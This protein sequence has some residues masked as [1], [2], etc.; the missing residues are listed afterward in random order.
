MPD[1]T[2]P[3][4][5]SGRLA[6]LAALLVFAGVIG[7][8]GVSPRP[9]S[10]TAQAPGNVPIP[11]TGAYFG[12]FVHYG[13]DSIGEVPTFESHAQ[14]QVAIV[15]TNDHFQ[16][17]VY[18]PNFQRIFAMGAVP[19]HTNS[20]EIDCNQLKAGALDA[21]IRRWGQYYAT[22]KPKPVFVRYMH[23]MNL[24]FGTYPWAAFRCGGAAGYIQAFQRVHDILVQAGAT[25]VLHVW[26]PNAYW[27]ANDASNHLWF[28]QY[29][30]GDAYVDWMCVDGYDWYGEYKPDGTK[31]PDPQTFTHM[32]SA[33]LDLLESTSSKPIILGELGVVEDPRSPTWKPNWLRDAFTVQI[34]ARP[35][36]KAVMYTNEKPTYDGI[37]YN[38]QIESSAATQTAFVQA[39]ASSYYIPDI[40]GISTSPTPTPTPTPGTSTTTD[41][42]DRTWSFVSNGVGPV[43]KDRSNG[44]WPAGDGRTLTLNGTTYTKGLGVHAPAEI[45][46]ALGGACSRLTASVGVDDEVGANGSV[47]FQ[48]WADGVQLYDSGTMTGATA[49]RT[50]DVTLSGRNELRL[51]VTNGGD[52]INYDHADWAIPRIT[53]GGGGTP[54]GATTDL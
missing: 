14:K 36:I 22:L 2:V 38:F 52:N 23:E 24:N 6:I 5:R 46:Y 47:V 26:C 28:K 7:I 44:D 43:E 48:V 19:F 49:T 51:V 53:C 9:E 27:G 13:G 33:S 21:D 40:P 25:N 39:I 12:A 16:Y 50:L 41:L 31:Y 15:G 32:L 20:P 8:V 3:R 34:P 11:S 17:A 42:S 35:R 4:H 45:R 54:T 18:A 10:A 30:P 1:P 29:Y 37:T